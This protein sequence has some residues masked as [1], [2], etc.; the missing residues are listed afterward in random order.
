MSNPTQ[1]TGEEKEE[2]ESDGWADSESKKVIRAKLLSGEI[3]AT[4]RPKEIFDM[5]IEVHRPWKNKYRNW[6]DNLRRMRK[7][8]ERDKQRMIDDCIAYGHDLAIAK[9]YRTNRVAWHRS[10]AFRLL[11]QDI[12]DGRDKNMEPEQL[13]NSRREYRESPF[14]LTE[15]RKHLYQIRDAEPKRALRF[16][17][18]KKAWKYPELHKNHPRNQEES[19]DAS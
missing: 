19:N 11:K 2:E 10:E 17:K 1:E 6:S 5:D 3:T 12:K 9:T 7:N 8:V 16:E 13:Y 14:D 18:K 15:F 4:M